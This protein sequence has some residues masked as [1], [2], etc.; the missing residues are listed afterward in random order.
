MNKK[1]QIDYFKEDAKHWHEKY[2]EE[3]CEVKTYRDRCDRLMHQY[4]EIEKREIFA[5]AQLDIY[6]R[7]INE[8]V[9]DILE[10]T[11]FIV[12]KGNVY[13]IDE[14]VL[15][16]KNKAVETLDISA[17]FVAKIDID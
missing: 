11:D 7:L 3:V 9:F 1:E 4:H 12:Y 8:N 5:Q 10:D 6:R 13:K 14:R 15:S 17:Q 2:D 16:D